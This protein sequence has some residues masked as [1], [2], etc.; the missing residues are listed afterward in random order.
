MALLGQ[1]LRNGITGMWPN[2]R[3]PKSAEKRICRKLAFTSQL[4][5][6]DSETNALCRAQS[7]TVQ[8]VTK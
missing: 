4:N 8:H 2:Q 1:A 7:L 3:T 5:A 6:I